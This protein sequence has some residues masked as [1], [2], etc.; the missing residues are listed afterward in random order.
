MAQVSGAG[1]RGGDGLAAP[2]HNVAQ[3]LTCGVHKA[4]R[5]S[6]TS[7]DPPAAASPVR[8]RG[9]LAKKEQRA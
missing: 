6:G 3:H 1:R 5:E 8:A 4:A 9:R 7:N 2:L